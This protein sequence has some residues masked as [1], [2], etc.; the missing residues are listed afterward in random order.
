M[1]RM[2][3][4]IWLFVVL[5]VALWSLMGWALYALLSLDHHWLGELKPLLEQVP[6]GDWIER[7]IPGW[8]ALAA[9]SID[10]VQWALGWLGAAAPVV[11][12]LVWGL[13]VLALAGLGAG[14]SLIVVLLRD[15]PRPAPAS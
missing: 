14:L 10:A 8:Q 4:A 1:R 9:L 12:W 11:V 7:W 2:L 6:Y 15:R 13:G 3:T 5:G